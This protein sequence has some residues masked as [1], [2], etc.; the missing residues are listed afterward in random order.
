MVLIYLYL[1]FFCIVLCV[2]VCICVCIRIFL[3][4]SLYLYLYLSFL[5]V[6]VLVFLLVFVFVFAFVFVFF[7]TWSSCLPIP[8]RNAEVERALLLLWLPRTLDMQESFL[9]DTTGWKLSGTQLFYICNSVG[10]SC[11]ISAISAFANDTEQHQTLDILKSFL[12]VT[13]AIT[14]VFSAWLYLQHLR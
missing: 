11:F 6:S 12:W 1:Y 5:F 10:H 8:A 2:C 4:L 9:W 14:C 13:P 3:S 7:G